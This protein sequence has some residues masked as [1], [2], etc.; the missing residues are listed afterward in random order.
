MVAGTV[1]DSDFHVGESLISA[2]SYNPKGYF[3][4]KQIN[5]LNERI[6][7]PITYNFPRPLR[8][9]LK[10]AGPLLR[11]WLFPYVTKSGYHL[12]AY[13]SPNKDV[14]SPPPSCKLSIESR[15]EDRPFLY[16]DPRFCYTIP[17]WRKFAPKSKVIVVF[18][19]FNETTESMI[20]YVQEHSTESLTMTHRQG[21]QIVKNMYIRI[22]NYYEND[23]DEPAPRWLFVH[24]KQVLNGTAF[25]KLEEFTGTSVNRD[26][27]DPSLTR[28]KPEQQDLP[29]P[30]WTIYR[31][32][33]SLAEADADILQEG[34]PKRD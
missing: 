17:H 23:S 6:L 31:R 1:N 22:L 7:E 26:F 29:D 5:R 19:N 28:S 33:C 4:T 14:P 20:E 13:L 34:P 10:G 25:D 30:V 15:V 2:D 9:N 11:R 27:P 18:R 8:R 24:Q 16:K 3:E 21:V 12:F 32:L